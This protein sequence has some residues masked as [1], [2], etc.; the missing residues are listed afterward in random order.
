MELPNDLSEMD[1]YIVNYI[2]KKAGTAGKDDAEFA[3]SQMLL[4]EGEDLYRLVRPH[5]RLFEKKC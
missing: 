1:L 4:A 2:G 5:A 3:L